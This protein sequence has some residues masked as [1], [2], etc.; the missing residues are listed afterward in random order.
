MSYRVGV[1]IGGT[2]TDFALVDDERC[3]T[4]IYKQL[5]TPDDPSRAVIEG[6][7]HLLRTTS[8][9]IGVLSSV[10]HGTTLVTNALIERRGA[11]TGMLVTAGMQDTFDIGRERRYDIYDLRLKFPE[12]LV[13]R[14]MRRE[15]RERVMANGSTRRPLDLEA[16][17]E[18]VADLV[19]N[20]QIKSLAVCL[21]H[22][23][24]NGENESRIKAAVGQAFPDLHVSISSEVVPFMREYERWN[25]TVMNAYVQPIVD[26]YVAQLEH[27]LAA[28]GFTGSLYLMSSSGGTLIPSTARDFPVRLLE[29]GPAA[30]ALMSAFHGR[31]LGLGEL[32]S[33]DMGGTTAKG[34]L[35]RNGRPLKAYEMEVARVHEFKEG[36]GLPVK[37]PVIDMIE[38]GSGGGSLADIDERGLVRVGPRSAGAAPG[39]ACYGLG[40]ELPTLTDANLILGYLDPRFFLGGDMA[41]D[42]D[43][44]RRAIEG[45]IVEPLDLDLARAA[46]GVHETVNEDVSRAFRVHAAECG[47]DYRRSNMIA[48]GGSGPMHAARVAR[49]LRIPKVVFPLGA[50][51]MSALGLLVSPI[52]FDTIR[53]RRADLQ[54]LDEP[55][56][57]EAYV[58]LT[59]EV[60]ALLQRAGVPPEQINYARRLDMRYSGQGHEVEVE[61]SSDNAN[62]S[63]RELFEDKYRQ[64]YGTTLSEPVEVVNWKLEASGPEPGG[65]AAYRFDRLPS[66][67]E[68]LKGKR[69]AY[70]PETGYLD[71][72]VYSRYALLPESEVEGPAL[73]EERESTVVIGVGDRA[74][75]D[76]RSNMILHVSLGA[77]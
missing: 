30:G 17:L 73:V 5:T 57:R 40:G 19:D 38:I 37:I 10:V 54:D 9:D 63:L 76:E 44:S 16:A 26:R 21:L 47:F 29:S 28:L 3:T 70:F 32:L 64:L 22:S 55:R 12:P 34:A 35:V 11:R 74:V 68:P 43:A 31:A 18:A 69:T 75:I 24:A 20:H 53:S 27:G 61:L 46:W 25:T 14:R 42:V 41:L 39:P 36:S 59:T 62:R 13:P 72:P 77:A 65:S 7:S 45:T 50:G 23:Y 71:C 60:A 58:P 56:L 2:F 49:K 6:I 67:S 4:A 33:F 1:D 52:S 48:F 51:V 66:Q 15:V 8:I